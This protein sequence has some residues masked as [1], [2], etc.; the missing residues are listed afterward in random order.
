VRRR[1]ASAVVVA[2]VAAVAVAAIVDAVRPERARSLDAEAAAQLAELGV[3]GTLVYADPG[4]RLHA[5]SLPGLT[6][7]RLPAGIGVACEI[8]VSPEG[9]HVAGGGA[10]WRRDG[11]QYAICRGTRVDV[12]DAAGG[13]ARGTF[14]GCAPAFR[15]DGML[16]FARDGG[17][18]QARL[19]R[20]LVPRAELERAA[21]A[22]PNAPEPPIDEL[23]V[24][25][26]AWTS[27][28]EVV[29]LIETR[30]GLGL[31]EFQTTVAGFRFGRLRW[32]R[33]FFGG[34]ERLSVSSSGDVLLEPAVRTQSPLFGNL[35]PSGPVDWSPDGRRLALA[36]RAS[37]FVVDPAAER[38]VRIPVTARDLAWR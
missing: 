6:P 1:V 7:A 29:A 10:R 28:F 30:F 13:P 21:R 23:R 37:V 27:P 4:C 22:H 11:A 34:Y 31:P 8:S 15:P 12:V 32:Q 9:R 5:L 24:R 3:G 36:S 35:D 19:D 18:R 14:T 25:D 16:T 38:R 26:L 17:I 33:P 2:A 20:I